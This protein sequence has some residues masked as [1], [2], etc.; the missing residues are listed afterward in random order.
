MTSD[1]RHDQSKKRA[2]FVC[3]QD[4][5]WA[6]ATA[7]VLEIITEFEA[8]AVFSTMPEK[9]IEYMQS[10]GRGPDDLCEGD[11]CLLHL[12]TLDD[13]GITGNGDGIRHIRGLRCSPSGFWG[14]GIVFVVK[15]ALVKA[16][17]MRA[18]MFGGEP[19]GISAFSRHVTTGTC[20]IV[21]E[22]I[23]LNSLIKEL[24]GVIPVGKHRWGMYEKMG[25][26]NLLNDLVK[27]AENNLKN[28]NHAAAR[29]SLV[30]AHKEWRIRSSQIQRLLIHTRRRL[31]SE[32][33]PVH[34][35]EDPVH[36]RELVEWMR[37]F[38]MEICIGT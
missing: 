29:N 7:K 10:I 30:E 33:L 24:S 13:D 4:A 3:S 37:A 32:I 31:E 20:Q 26:L 36:M 9:I 34:I 6:K 22:L 2:V 16:A 17:L 19:G 12:P 38:L 18:D 14:G 11:V 5:L 21:T 23:Q 27:E 15:N 28:G 25:S 35:P 8:H 1:A